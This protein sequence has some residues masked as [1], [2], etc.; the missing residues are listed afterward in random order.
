MVSVFVGRIIVSPFVVV[1]AFA[2]AALDSDTK[3]RHTDVLLCA[4]Y[5]FGASS[6]RAP[7]VHWQQGGVGGGIFPTLEVPVMQQQRVGQNCHTA[8]TYIY[9]LLC[10]FMCP[11]F[12]CRCTYSSS[13]G[14]SVLWY[15][16]MLLRKDPPPN[17][18][19]RFPFCHSR[20]ACP[21]Y[22]YHGG[23]LWTPAPLPPT[24]FNLRAPAQPRNQLTFIFA[25]NF[26]MGKSGTLK[27]TDFGFARELAPN[28]RLYSQFG[29]PEYVAPEV[30]LVY[31][32]RYE[33]STSIPRS[34]VFCACFFFVILSCDSM[35]LPSYF[36]CPLLAFLSLSRSLSPSFWTC[37]MTGAERVRPR[38]AGRRVGPGRAHLRASRRP[39]A[40]QVGQRRR[41]V[42]AHRGWRLRLSRGPGPPCVG[43]A[44]YEIHGEVLR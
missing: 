31:M 12:V 20:L 38:D 35:F 8:C 14:K 19:T 9:T 2:V 34:P 43:K 15:P 10:Q 17:S 3:R 40:V 28:E 27:L 23:S 30:S 4:L 21:L 16:V 44:I 41:D 24:N 13:I 11:L 1:A 6:F 42:R 39:D 37:Y 32:Y 36:I 25:E 5:H 22:V 18:H 7:R 33:V 29:T 26:L